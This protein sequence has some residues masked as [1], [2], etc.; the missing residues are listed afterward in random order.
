MNGTKQT[1]GSDT[2][3]LIFLEPV[4]WAGHPVP[5][6]QWLVR[7]RIPRPAVT[8][9]SGDGATGKTL[10][11]LQLASA[12]LRGADWLGAMVDEPG[13][14]D[15]YTAEEPQDEIHRRLAR[16]TERQ[17]IGLANLVGLRVVS[18]A[19][20]DAVLAVVDRK[21][22]VRPTSLFNDFANN[23]VTRRPS[24]III[25]SAADVFAVQEN[26]RSQARQCVGLLR[27]LAFKAEAA[28]LLLAHPSLSG[29][30]TNRGTSGS[31]AWN[32]SARSRL[33]LSAP[34][35]S[36]EGDPDSD[37]R[38]LETKKSNYG[39]PGECVRLRWDNGIFVLASSAASA[40]QIATEHSIERSYLD[41]LDV[42][43]ARGL[44]VFPHP[45]RGYAPK[46][47]AGMPEAAGSGWKAFAG[48]QARLMSAGQIHVVAEGYQ[49][50]QVH[51]IA[52]KPIEAHANGNAVG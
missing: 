25:E 51:R 28:V 4:Q 26:D 32:N 34:S 19:D 10:I 2:K 49:S 13:P 29:M 18:R 44:R 43:T 30:A 40:Q 14:A 35:T 5:E 9:L 45:G 47:F 37:V 48:A 50:R 12:S 11:A 33:Y 20:D 38:Q 46:V 8:I 42:A 15:F 7:N 16:I 52:R 39:P 22:L 6:Q 17:G 21:G 1:G 36:D 23:A 27:R 24:L 31:T 3:P 41:C